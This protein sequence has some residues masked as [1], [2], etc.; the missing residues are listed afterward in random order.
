MADQDPLEN[1]DAI[2]LLFPD[3]RPHA[4]SGIH[5][6][7]RDS[8]RLQ[9][10]GAVAKQIDILV[11]KKFY[12]AVRIGLGGLHGEQRRW[13]PARQ[14]WWRKRIEKIRPAQITFGVENPFWRREHCIQINP[15][16][17]NSR[18]QLFGRG[19]TLDIQR[20]RLRTETEIKIWQRGLIRFTK[21]EYL[22]Q[23]SEPNEDDGRIK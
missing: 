22:A 1:R 7:P 21:R 13:I 10:F 12:R 3:H 16:S 18:F 4:S 6:F 5:E 8:G 2:K 9:D 23:A 17:W 20:W 11:Q 14:R 15:H 19:L